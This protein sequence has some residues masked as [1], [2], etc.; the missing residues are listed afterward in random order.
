MSNKIEQALQETEVP[1]FCT[2]EKIAV[3]ILD[4]AKR[5]MIRNLLYG[6]DPQKKGTSDKP[7]CLLILYALWVLEIKP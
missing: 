1:V 6:R 7:R 4:L 5:E 3:V 2:L